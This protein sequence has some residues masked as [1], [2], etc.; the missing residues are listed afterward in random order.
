[1]TARTKLHTITSQQP[2][3]LM[4]LVRLLTA[5]G[6]PLE[7]GNQFVKFPRAEQAA[8]AMAEHLREM[9]FKPLPSVDVFS[10]ETDENCRERVHE[11]LTHEHAHKCHDHHDCGHDHSHDHHHDHGH[12]H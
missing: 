9:G 10:P 1:M 4:R 3:V 2:A 6:I 5:A 8:D 12:S 7:V 11:L